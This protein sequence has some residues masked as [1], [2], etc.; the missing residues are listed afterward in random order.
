MYN[1]AANLAGMHVRSTLCMGFADLFTPFKSPSPSPSFVP[2]SSLR[3]SLNSILAFLSP[4]KLVALTLIKGS[5]RLPCQLCVNPTLWL[6]TSL[7]K[8]GG[9]ED[10]PGRTILDNHTLFQVENMTPL[11]L[12]QSIPRLPSARSLS[13]LRLS[14][15]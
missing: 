3:C 4:H 14:L 12:Y 13:G 11:S 10:C 9:N 15:S 5:S 7:V 6:A 2:F 8:H 1:H